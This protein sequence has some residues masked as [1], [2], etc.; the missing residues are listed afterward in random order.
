MQDVGW[1]C[2]KTLANESDAYFP[3]HK[4]GEAQLLEVKSCRSGGFVA[5]YYLIPTCLQMSPSRRG[6]LSG[7]L[8]QW[9]SRPART[10]PPSPSEPSRHCT[11]LT[12]LDR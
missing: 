3:C 10:I 11:K 12:T 9:L 4:T 5:N 1:H 7:T 8:R 2:L 6:G